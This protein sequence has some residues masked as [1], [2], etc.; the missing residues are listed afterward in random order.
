MEGE[1]RERQIEVLEH[2]VGT[3]TI[4][5][6]S[7]WIEFINKHPDIQKTFLEY[8]SD[9]NALLLCQ[10]DQLRKRGLESYITA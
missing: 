1:E 4:E 5:T 3:R 9:A 6:F 7:L 10:F 8:S 2:H